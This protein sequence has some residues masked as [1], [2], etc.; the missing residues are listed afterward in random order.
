[1]VLPLRVGEHC[2]VLGSASGVDEEVSIGS[3]VH[4]G[5]QEMGEVSEFGDVGRVAS[6]SV[7][8]WVVE[9]SAL[10]TLPF[11]AFQPE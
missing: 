10:M 3:D 2:A 9:G 7:E 6:A 4:D 11:P 1:M 8:L 5:V